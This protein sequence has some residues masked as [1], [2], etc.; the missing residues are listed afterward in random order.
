[1]IQ[2]RV[3]L[4]KVLHFCCYAECQYAECQY[5]E[6]QYAECQY[7]ECYNAQCHQERSQPY[8]QGLDEGGSVDY[9]P[10]HELIKCQHLIYF[11]NVVCDSSEVNKTNITTILHQ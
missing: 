4:F 11:Q 6:C 10:T 8:L 1:M 7:A 9:S 5:A 2:Y 3:L